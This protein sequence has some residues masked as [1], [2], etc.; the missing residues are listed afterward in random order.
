MLRRFALGITVLGVAFFACSKTSLPGGGTTSFDSPLYFFSTMTEL[1]VEVAYE[2]E[3]EPFDGNALKGRP[4]WDF[5]KENLQA[6]FEGRSK[7]VTFHVPTQTSEMTAISDQAGD[8]FTRDKILELAAAFRQGRSTETHGNF[9]VLFLDGY[10]SEDGTTKETNV[11]GVNL[12][13]TTIIAMFKP[14][15]ESTQTG[16]TQLVP[17]YVEQS[18]IVHELGHALG[19]VN[20]G[21]PMVQ[22]HQDTAHGKHCDNDQCT[23]YYLNEGASDLKAFILAYV[24]STDPSLVIFDSKCLADTRAYQP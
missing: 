21:V 10:Y 19:L 20:N 7:T 18:T 6:L 23:M 22:S 9:F 13:G 24:T 4:L 1:T 14:V 3:A 12:S 16:V 15:I 2:P 8:T 17:K 11:I 5:T